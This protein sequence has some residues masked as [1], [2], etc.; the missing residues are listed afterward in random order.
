MKADNPKLF[1]SFK[2]APYPGV[3]PGSPSHVT[4]GGI[5][6]A[7]SA[8][9]PHPDLAKQAI[10]CI[11][12]RPNQAIAA[13]KGGLPPTIMSLYSDPSFI[14]AGYP[15]AATIRQSLLAAS[16]RPKTPAYQNISIVIS[17]AV[18]PPGSINPQST[19]NQI[20]GGIVN[21]L[22]DKGLIP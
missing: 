20:K 19:L 22:A 4:I 1:K 8:F 14:K 18:S 6:L 7:V 2:W 17:H 11:R 15:F 3:N 5:D 10:L 13:I 12:D 21:A 9:S 16:V